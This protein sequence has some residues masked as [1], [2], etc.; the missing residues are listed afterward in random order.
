MQCKKF[1]I[2]L[3]FLVALIFGFLMFTIVSSHTG[4]EFDI[5]E[6]NDSMHSHME[7]MMNN[8][9]EAGGT[10]NYDIAQIKEMVR[11]L[12]NNQAT[13]Q[14]GQIIKE[15]AKNHPESFSLLVSNV[16]ISEVQ[17]LSA[18]IWQ[19]AFLNNL[20]IILSV[21]WIIVGALTIIYLWNKI[22]IKIK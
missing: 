16:A 13:D 3:S 4:S 18:R 9:T 21:I 11:K 12:M 1:F 7:E 19:T 10:Q 15:F 2:S 6:E 20:L 5:I 22:E 17:K 8:N 14:E